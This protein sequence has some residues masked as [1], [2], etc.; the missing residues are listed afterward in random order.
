M[1]TRKNVQGSKMASRPL[2]I[3]KD[4]IYVHSNVI[5]LADTEERKDLYQYDEIQCTYD[6]YF[7]LDKDEYD[8]PNVVTLQVQ[9]D[10]Q[11]SI[12]E[13]VV[14]ETVDELVAEVN[15]LDDKLNSINQ[16]NR[17]LSTWNCVTGLPVT[18]PANMP[19][20][21]KNGDYYIIG[22]VSEEEN[23]KPNGDRKSVV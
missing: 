11:A 9:N 14:S 6:E 17:F 12:I 1:I 15:K 13:D 20:I 21:Y 19:F 22:T 23:Y 16:L 4:T 2:I 5:K 18:N 7:A 10:T 8:V 3:D